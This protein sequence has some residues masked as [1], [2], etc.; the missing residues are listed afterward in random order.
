MNRQWQAHYT[1][2]KSELH[3]PDE[4][5]VRLLASYL[6]D[7]EAAEV[8]AADIGCGSGRH[9]NLLKD[10]KK[11]YPNVLTKSGLMVGLG[12]TDEEILQVMQ[13]LRESDVDMLTIGQYLQPSNKHLPVLR[14]V[15]PDTFAFFEENARQM[16]FT[17]AH[18]GPLV[19]SSYM[20]GK[21]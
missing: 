12:E 20:A 14:F 4:N 21:L 2:K 8:S 16:G 17:H 9:L 1:K 19:R 3:Y 7:R 6:K 15:H 5:L 13:D 10:F 11:R 18:C